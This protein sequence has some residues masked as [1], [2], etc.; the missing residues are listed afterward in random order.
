MYKSLL[1]RKLA[2][3][4]PV[5]QRLLMR[6]MGRHWVGVGEVTWHNSPMGYF[7]LANA[8]VYLRI[9]ANKFEYLSVTRI[10]TWLFYANIVVALYLLI[11]NLLPCPLGPINLKNLIFC[12]RKIKIL[13][14]FL[15]ILQTLTL[16]KITSL[17]NT[18]EVIFKKLSWNFQFLPKINGSRG[19]L[20]TT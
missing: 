7:W 8:N 11:I 1:T 19:I 10:G 16:W 12:G 3:I 5:Q 6:S 13:S 9:S 17:Q 20:I 14:L 4:F 18:K 2:F 15:W